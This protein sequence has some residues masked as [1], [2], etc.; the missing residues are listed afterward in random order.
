MYWV[1]LNYFKANL[2]DVE[3][4]TL[5]L[6]AAILLVRWLAHENHISLS[7]A[8]KY[9]P[10]IVDDQDSFQV[11]YYNNKIF[12]NKEDHNPAKSAIL[13]DL[14]SLELTP[15]YFNHDYYSLIKTIFQ[16]LRSGKLDP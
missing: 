8:G 1:C 16:D 13:T 7:K 2:V 11:E 4:Y 3:L 6:K 14:V 12:F 10:Y 5:Y 15:I 9:S